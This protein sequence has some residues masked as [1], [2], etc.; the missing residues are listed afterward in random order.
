M[1]ERATGHHE[2]HEAP[3]GPPLPWPLSR[4]PWWGAGGG[5]GLGIV[6]RQ[7]R[8]ASWSG[9]ELSGAVTRAAASFAKQS[10]TG[11]G[12]SQS[13]CGVRGASRSSHGAREFRGASNG[14]LCGAAAGFAE[15]SRSRE[16]QGASWGGE[17]HRASQ[18]SRGDATQSRLGLGTLTGHDFMRARPLVLK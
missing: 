3:L 4:A 6:E 12:V 14:E 5:A 13:S 1:T 18:S 7:W 9:R 15:Q 16:H 8:A 17:L 2:V 10:L 11:E